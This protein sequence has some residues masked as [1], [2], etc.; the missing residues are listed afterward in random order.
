MTTTNVLAIAMQRFL[1][2]DMSVRLLQMARRWACFTTTVAIPRLIREERKLR[3]LRRKSWNP[4]K[5]PSASAAVA[6]KYSVR[7]FQRKAFL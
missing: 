4:L 6:Y 1:S 7:S 2:T 5:V 3:L